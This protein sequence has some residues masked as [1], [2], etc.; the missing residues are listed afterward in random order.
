MLSENKKE[1]V[2]RPPKKITPQRL[3]NIA[4]YYLRRFETSTANLRSVLRRRVDEYARWDKAFDKPEAYDWVETIIKEFVSLKY[5]DDARFAEIKIRSYLGAGKS[6]RYILGK[7]KEKGIDD[8]LAS[9]LL[10]NQEYD[11]FDAALKLA[12]RKQIGPFSPI[13]ETRKER[14]TKDLGV[15]VRAGFDY[16]VAV[17]VLEMEEE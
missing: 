13:P 1:Y 4:L 3:K 9:K 11:P 12:R 5:V 16:D 10:A 8:S 6:P 14:R 17:K 2:K 15:L 7:L